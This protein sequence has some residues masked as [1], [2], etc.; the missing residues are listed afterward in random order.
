MI[1]GLHRVIRY[2]LHKFTN[3]KTNNHANTIVC[4]NCNDTRKYY[5]DI[6]SDPVKVWLY[7]NREERMDASLDI[8]DDSRR[9]FHLARYDF[10]CKFCQ[11]SVVA[12]IACGTGYGTD[13]ILNFGNAKEVYGI[14]I[15]GDS[16]NYAKIYHSK[17]G[18]EYICTS[19]EKTGLGNETIDVVVSFETIEHVPNDLDLIKEFY[20][21]LKH[22]GTLVCSTPNG[23]PIEIATHHI[24]EYERNSFIAL[25]SN[26]FEIVTLYNQNSGG[27]SPF[28][29]GQD[30]GITETTDNNFALAECFI[31]VCKKK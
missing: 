23:W 10:A 28:N 17:P 3:Y 11:N 1:I 30:K 8:F 4:G 5:E 6:L 2:I 14:D 24:R 19:G 21:I 25:L 9:Q 26:W 16:I 7:K 15:C 12:D 20:R 31:A 18:I 13:L 27:S 22:G 29:H